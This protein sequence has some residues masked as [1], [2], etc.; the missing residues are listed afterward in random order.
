M[1]TRSTYRSA[2]APAPA[3]APGA[4]E[5]ELDLEAL[6]SSAR[7]WGCSRRWP[8]LS[9]RGRRWAGYAGRGAGGAAGAAA[10][11]LLAGREQQPERMEPFVF[12][13]SLSDA[14]GV[15]GRRRGGW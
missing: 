2:P 14:R 4:P 11:G 10:Q 1:T 3:P 9:V 6:L 12:G 8:S 5:P 13:Q 15:V 7:H